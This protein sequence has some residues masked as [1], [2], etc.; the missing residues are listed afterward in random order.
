MKVFTPHFDP[1]HSFQEARDSLN[2]EVRGSWFPRSICGRGFAFCAYVRMLL[3]ALYVFFWA[4]SFDYIVLDLVS[5]PIPLLRLLNRRVLFYCH[6][7]DK[8][9]CTDR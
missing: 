3:C 9:L 5:F 6:Y 8:L 7:P 4:G 2:I 1:R